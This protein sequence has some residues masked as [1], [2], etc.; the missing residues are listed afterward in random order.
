MQAPLLV[1]AA[2]RRHPGQGVQHELPMTEVDALRQTGGAGRVEHGGAGVLVEIGE[3]GDRLGL[4]QACFV[5]DREAIGQRATFIVQQH[6]RLQFRQLP[7]DALKHGQEFTIGQD[8]LGPA[9]LQRVGDLFRRQAD[10]HHHQHRAD[11][12]HREVAFQ[13]AVAVPVHHRHRITGLH[14]Q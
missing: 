14:P 3:G 2:Q 1:R 13:I 4:S 5:F 9:V 10:V 11:H 12:R 6:P 7:G 8:H